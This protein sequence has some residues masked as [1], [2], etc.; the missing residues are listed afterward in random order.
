MPREVEAIDLDDAIRRYLAGELMNEIGST[1]GVSKGYIYTRL[2][3]AGVVRSKSEA[4]ALSRKPAKIPGLEDLIARYNAGEPEYHLAREAGIDRGVLRRAFLRAGVYIRTLKEVKTA[5]YARM[6]DDKKRSITSA[7]NR[8]SRGRKATDEELIKR[9]KSKQRLLSHATPVE[10]DLAAWLVEQGFT[11]T[12][13]GALGPYNI[14]I[15]IDEP[16]IAVEIYGGGWHCSG[17]HAARFLERTEYI[18]NR[19]WSVLIVWVDGRRYPLGVGGYNYIIAMA[20]RIGSHPPGRGEYR[21][22]LGDGKAAPGVKKYFNS[23]SIIESLR[24]GD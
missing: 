1:F 9:A 13:Q 21:V 2:K 19:G 11:V 10:L 4:A 24:G 6:T 5:S 20:E 14:D 8:A 17:R 7:A 12:P 16:R 23:R 18:L 15:A 22:V 3:K